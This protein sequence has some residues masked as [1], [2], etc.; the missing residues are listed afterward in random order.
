MC[1]LLLHNTEPGMAR[2]WTTNEATQLY[3]IHRP[4]EHRKTM[5]LWAKISEVG[6]G[7]TCGMQKPVVRS[8]ASSVKPGRSKTRSVAPASLRS[9]VVRKEDFTYQEETLW[10]LR[11]VVFNHYWSAGLI[12]FGACTN[13]SAG[14]EDRHSSDGRSNPQWGTDKFRAVRGKSIQGNFA[15][16]WQFFKLPD[17]N[18]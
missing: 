5:A 9:E 15:K 16:A 10:L 17:G 6:R 2:W 8:H 14:R 11:H 18:F 12:G 3:L 7:K 4:T 1:F 13:Q